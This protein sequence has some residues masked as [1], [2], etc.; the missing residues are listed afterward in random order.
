[1]VSD[2]IEGRLSSLEQG[3]LS[4]KEGIDD[5]KKSVEKIDDAVTLLMEKLDSRYPSKESVDLR[6]AELKQ[7]QE[8]FNKRLNEMQ[9]QLEKL[10]SWR[11]WIAGG[12]A[13]AA[14]IIIAL[15]HAIK[16]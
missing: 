16:L 11:N 13:L 14:F 15:S 7:Q 8:A 9:K 5:L 1:M 4:L 3:F 2:N 12:I 6:I 10:K